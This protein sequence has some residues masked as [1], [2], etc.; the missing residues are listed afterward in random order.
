[1][2]FTNHSIINEA[3]LNSGKKAFLKA[4]QPLE[5]EYFRNATDSIESSMTI[6]YMKLLQL[7][8]VFN[9]GEQ[10]INF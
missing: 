8:N 5:I 2:S 6:K 4:I 9:L 7:I 1:M 10:E 3:N